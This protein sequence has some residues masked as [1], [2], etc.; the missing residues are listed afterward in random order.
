V[1]TLNLDPPRGLRGR[2]LYRALADSQRRWIEHCEETGAY[3]QTPS[4][5]ARGISAA[6]IREADEAA[7]RTS[8]AETSGG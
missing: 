8:G 1:K 6:A 4:K 3:D 5:T 2:R 7:L